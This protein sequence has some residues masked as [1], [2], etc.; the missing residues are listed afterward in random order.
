MNDPTTPPVTKEEYWQRA[1]RCIEA[2]SKIDQTDPVMLDVQGMF[3]ISYEDYMN[4]ANNW[5]TLC[6]AALAL[7][8]GRFDEAFKLF[9]AILKREPTNLPALMGRVSGCFRFAV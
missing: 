5:F 2:A 8:T 4:K 9:D 1:R 6:L 3:V 7:A